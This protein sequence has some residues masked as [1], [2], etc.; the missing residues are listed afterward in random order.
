MC[1]VIRDLWICANE[2]CRANVDSGYR[3]NSW[4]L[5]DVGPTYEEACPNYYCQNVKHYE[6][7]CAN[8]E[9][10]E[11]RQQQLEQQRQAQE[12]RERQWRE[13]QGR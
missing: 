5:C 8:C 13:Q 4:I 9:R 3:G 1:Y 2:W 12:E 6:Y 10:E 11:R 7:K